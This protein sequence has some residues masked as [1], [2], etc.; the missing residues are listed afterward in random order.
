MLVAPLA[1]A[2]AVAPFPGGCGSQRPGPGEILATG[3]DGPRRP[4]IV[5]PL[6]RADR[7]DRWTERHHRPG[8]FAQL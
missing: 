3:S 8:Q 4:R 5:Q 6:P 1:F 2:A 7:R